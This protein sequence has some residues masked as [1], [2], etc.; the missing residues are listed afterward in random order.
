MSI[1]ALSPW[2][3]KLTGLD[4]VNGN[5]K[6]NVDA[7][8]VLQAM[9]DY[10]KYDQAVI[11]TSDGDFYSLVRHL[12]DNQKLRAVLSP[13]KKTCSSLLK[14]TAKERIVYMDNLVQKIGERPKTKNTA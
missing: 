14:Q 3:G 1:G 12:Y 5:I 13:Y 11:I 9:L 8:L 6:G 10:D 2:A 7:D 4:D